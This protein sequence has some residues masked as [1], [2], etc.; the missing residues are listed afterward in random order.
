VFDRALALFPSSSSWNEDGLRP[1]PAVKEKSWG[2]S[3]WE[4]CTTTIRPRFVLVKV[5][6]MTSPSFASMFDGGD[7]S[8][9]V[10]LERSQPGGTLSATE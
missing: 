8:E 10:A 2:S 1:P 4:S 7:P 3:S 6:L 5:Q 9:H